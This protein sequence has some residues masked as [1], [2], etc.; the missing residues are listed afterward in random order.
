MEKVVNALE[1]NQY[2]KINVLC[3]PQLGK[4][5]LY[6]TVSKKGQYDEIYGL[7]TFIAYADGNNDLIGIS[8]RIGCPIDRLIDIVEMLKGS[9]LL[10]IVEEK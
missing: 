5:G 2:Y 7:T 3:E 10:D 6:P 4:R 9:G 8:D 1:H